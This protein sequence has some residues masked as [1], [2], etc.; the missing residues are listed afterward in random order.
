M[1]VALF[2]MASFVGRIIRRRLLHCSYS[3]PITV[4]GLIALG[5]DEDDE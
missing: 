2:K 1:H 3:L 4:E 5:N